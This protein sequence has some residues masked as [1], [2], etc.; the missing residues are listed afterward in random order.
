M[1]QKI[2]LLSWFV[3]IC[4]LAAFIRSMVWI[5]TPLI[6]GSLIIMGGAAIFISRGEELIDRLIKFW[7][8]TFIP[9]P[10]EKL[11]IEEHPSELEAPKELEE[12]DKR[13]FEAAKKEIEAGDLKKAE[14]KI[15]ELKKKY[16]RNFELREI[17]THLRVRGKL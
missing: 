13:K 7:G 14:A 5:N 17:L 9:K 10:E 1:E 11:S 6:I 8:M 4:A 15:L 12:A 3:F 16:P 2:K